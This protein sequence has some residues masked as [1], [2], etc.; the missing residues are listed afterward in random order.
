MADEVSLEMEDVVI[1]E[2]RLARWRVGW[3]CPG[4]CC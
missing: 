1:C 3:T 4:S 2:M